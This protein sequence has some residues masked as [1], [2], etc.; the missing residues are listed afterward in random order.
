MIHLAEFYYRHIKK[1]YMYAWFTL[2]VQ[3]IG[4]IV[5]VWKG[6]YEVHMAWFLLL[7]FVIWIV[8]S[9]DYE[10]CK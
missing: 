5:Q 9:F 2:L 3:S 8:V 1:H 6:T 10:G 4:A 7:S